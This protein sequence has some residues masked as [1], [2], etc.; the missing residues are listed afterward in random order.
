VGGLC[1][2]PPRPYR[3]L[4]ERL[5]A[6][7]LQVGDCWIWQGKRNGSGYGQ[8]NV[9]RGGK[10]VSLFAHR[11]SYEYYKGPIP[12]ELEVDHK[13]CNKLCVAPDH[14]R[15]LPKP[16]NGRRGNGKKEFP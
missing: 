2:R 4:E 9:W 11:V 3:N 7:S 15:L 12:S 10:A 14:L 8:L 6:N 13:C 5:L 16:E 1:L